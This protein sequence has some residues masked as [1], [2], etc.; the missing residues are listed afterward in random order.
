[1]FLAQAQQASANNATDRFVQSLMTV[2][3][4]KPEVLDLF[5]ADEWAK[6]FAENLGVNPRMFESDEQVQQ[7]RQA[8]AQAQSLASKQQMM[9]QH[10][11]TVCRV[12]APRTR[13]GK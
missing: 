9:Q 2:S 7:T 4:V 8:R 12:M 10:A 13:R 5:N 1:M 11:E 6:R 3:Q